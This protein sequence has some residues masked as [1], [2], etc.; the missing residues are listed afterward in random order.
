MPSS[1]ADPW[2]SEAIANL[3]VTQTC[4]RKKQCC[5]CSISAQA[6]QEAPSAPEEFGQRGGP[7]PPRSSCCLPETSAHCNIAGLLH[8][9][10]GP[11]TPNRPDPLRHGQGH[12]QVAARG[13]V[14][15]G[16]LAD[17]STV[18]WTLPR[19]SLS[20]CRL[21]TSQVPI[22]VPQAQ[23]TC[24]HVMLG[25]QRQHYQ[26]HVDGTGSLCAKCQVFPMPF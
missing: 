15:P 22:P 17:P 24:K 19:P 9:G 3:M 26:S 25:Q 5:P 16:A 13:C 8:H 20:H 6:V 7:K 10:P 1:M 18:F 23:V 4:A 12:K 21:R 2:S 11:S 14:D